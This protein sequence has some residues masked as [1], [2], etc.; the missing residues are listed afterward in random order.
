M[1]N[2]HS[3]SVWEDAAPDDG[4]VPGGPLNGTELL[5]PLKMASKG[6]FLF[7]AFYFNK[8]DIRVLKVTPPNTSCSK[9][10]LYPL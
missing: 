4:C 8:I 1:C 6:F 3:A 9:G 5:I 10:S 7:D 2:R